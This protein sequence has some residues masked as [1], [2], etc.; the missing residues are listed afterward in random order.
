MQK[1]KQQTE[2][3]LLSWRFYSFFFFFDV[4]ILEGF[5]KLG[6]NFTLYKYPKREDQNI[7]IQNNLSYVE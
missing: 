2:K 5:D 7:Y 4:F 3:S 1:A 6:E